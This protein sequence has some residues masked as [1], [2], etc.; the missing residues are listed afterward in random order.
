MFRVLEP[1]KE[2]EF[3]PECEKGNPEPVT[4]YIVP[5]TYGQFTGTIASVKEMSGGRYS[6]KTEDVLKS[7]IKKILNVLWPGSDKPV[8]VDSPG[9]VRRF[10]DSCGTQEAVKI[11]QEVFRFI[12]TLSIPNEDEQGN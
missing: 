11:M 2:Y 6:I 12:Q 7:N 9:Q 3:I 8:T 1:E 5:M 4:F 10:I